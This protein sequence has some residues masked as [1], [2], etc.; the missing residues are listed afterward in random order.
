MSESLAKK[1]GLYEVKDVVISG[2]AK[3]TAANGYRDARFEFPATI[4]IPEG[5]EEIELSWDDKK[6]EEVVNGS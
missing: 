6:E 3:G 4:R 2:V 1:I 5:C